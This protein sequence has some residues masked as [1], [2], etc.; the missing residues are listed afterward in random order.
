MRWKIDNSA[1]ATTVLDA[2]GHL[3]I[4]RDKATLQEEILDALEVEHQ[5]KTVLVRSLQTSMRLVDVALAELERQGS[6]ESFRM[7]SERKRMD[8]FWCISGSAAK[9][10]AATQGFRAAETL[11]AFQAI[12]IQRASKQ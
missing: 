5:P 1:R 2:R 4:A 10:R 11:A 8:V 9:P 6:I 12:A 7:M 3:Q